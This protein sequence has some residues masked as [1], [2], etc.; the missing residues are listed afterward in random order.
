MAK[1]LT[2]TDISEEDIFKGIRDSAE[3]TLVV[4]DK[5][6]ATLKETASIGKG[7]MS[8]LDP[9]SLSDL[10]EFNLLSTE[11]IKVQKEAEKLAQ[12]KART[13]KI[14]AQTDEALVK[15]AEK[16]IKAQKDEASAYA[17]LSKELNN[18]RK[19]YKDLA[20]QNK[21]NTAE[22]QAL[23]KNITELDKKLKDVDATVGQHQ[24]NVGNYTEATTNLKKELRALTLQLQNMDESNP[25]YDR[26][27]R[28]AGQYRDQIQ[29]TTNLIKATA[30]SGLE[31]FSKGLAGIGKVGIGA[32]QGIESS[33]ALMGVES[34]K[35]QETL[36]RI[37]ALAGLSDALETLGGLGDTFKEIK[38]SIKGAWVSLV[39]W[40][41]TKR[42]D[43]AVTTA[44]TTATTG[45]TFATKA[46]G[47]AMKALPIV[48]IIAGI[49]ALVYALS[50]WNKQASKTEIQQQA[51]S[52]TMED[53]KNGAKEALITVQEVGSAFEG[54]KKGVISKKEALETYNEKLGG[55]LGYATSL[56]EAEALYAKKTQAFIQAT[57]LRSQAQAL[58]AK[59]AEASADAMTAGLEDNTSFFDKVMFGTKLATNLTDA[60][61]LLKEANKLQTEATEK[62][63]K[64]KQNEA[65]IINK[66]AEKMLMDAMSLEKKYGISVGGEQAKNSDKK[67]ET[68]KRTNKELLK[69]KQDYNK[70]IENLEAET[71]LEK[72]N[73]K[74]KGEIEALNIALEGSKKDI[75]A[76]QLYK[77]TMIA[78][79]KAYQI[80]LQKIQLD[81][82]KARQ[83][84]EQKYRD[85]DKFKKEKQNE[86]NLQIDKD[87]EDEYQ[88]LK[89]ET[90]AK[91]KEEE[92]RLAN[93]KAK[94]QEVMNNIVQVGT[95][96]FIKKSNERI[97]Q[98]DKEIQASEQH[99]ETLKTLA[100]NGNINAK[101][102]L[103]LELQNQI[104]ANKQKEKELKK[105][106]RIELIKTAYSTYQAKVQSGSKQPLV[107]TIKDI[108][109]LNAFISALPTFF[110]GTED[111]GKGGGIDGK[112]GFLSVLHPKER[113]V[114]Q[115]INEKLG[116][117]SNQELGSIAE[118]IKLNNMPFNKGILALNFGTDKIVERLDSLENAIKN[119][120]E[121]NIQLESIVNGAMTIIRQ[122]KGNGQTIT[123]RYKVRS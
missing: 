2:R 112:G 34:E 49:G 95:D 54:A 83:E 93:E 79:E 35:V 16:K 33:M 86:D 91:I 99:Y 123:N 104:E 71:E 55:T 10:K 66:L 43:I 6:D 36:M 103:E 76:Y 87:F 118:Q 42:A 20:V 15:I 81:E 39:Q 31:N 101:E 32:F 48:A 30:G 113:V 45:A 102:S 116:G 108:T 56:N 84:M 98:F 62:R 69:L 1:K 65:D 63:K 73:L 111:T 11:A 117:I 14:L 74:K 114:P 89:A 61:T 85:A 75:V 68:E 107:D 12:E 88:T 25:D 44:Q 96:F 52:D 58:F 64:Q 78:I 29:D 100:E 94:R 26:L 67:I 97:A 23:L 122:S 51:L 70:E 24:R 72:L 21:E 92:E 105:Q 110:D 47:F 90:D 120:P 37:Q 4:L 17:K 60:K 38:A 109:L 7:K 115:A 121:T 3:A 77:D 5:M 50:N 57:A 59:S 8:A 80:E 46:L 18:N 19:A 22:G 27:V 119:K 106:Q 28:Q 41:A 13:Q 53:Y 40:V 82:L 9:K